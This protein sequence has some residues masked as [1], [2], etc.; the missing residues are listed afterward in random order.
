MHIKERIK[1]RLE[2]A[3]ALL[4]KGMTLANLPNPGTMLNNRAAENYYYKK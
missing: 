4:T 3:Q 1:N 2:P